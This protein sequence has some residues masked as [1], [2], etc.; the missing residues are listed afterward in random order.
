[1]RL[2]DV[3]VLLGAHR[4]DHPQFESARRYV[5]DLVS[6]G[7]QFSVIDAVAGSFVRIATNRRIFL[8]PT[9]IAEAFAYVQ[10]LR[11]Q[12]AHLMLAPGAAHLD[13]FEGLCRD[14]DATGDLTPDAQLAAL[15]VEHDAEIVSFD[16]DFARFEKVRWAR[17]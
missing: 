9:P 12:P 3:N 16:R 10:A 5:D 2:L 11:A 6:G 15:A 8:A 4:I 17:P 13:L 1:V 14:A 7:H